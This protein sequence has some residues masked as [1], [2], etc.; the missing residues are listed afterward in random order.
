MIEALHVLSIG[1]TESNNL[2]RDVLLTRTKCRLFAAS[3]VW[4]LSAVLLSGKLDI[5]ILH[6]S[7]TAAEMRSCSVYIR[8]QWPDAKILLIR[9]DVEALDD[10]MY[11]ERIRPDASPE[12]LL[13]MIERLAAGARRR[14][15]MH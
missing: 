8:H 6:G 1:S 14:V 13:A 5:A 11:D 9:A 12:A 4:D 15:G 2:I 3:E 7:L 10:P